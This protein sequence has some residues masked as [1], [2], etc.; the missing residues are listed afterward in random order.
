MTPEGRLLKK[1][2]A[3]ARSQGGHVV[4]LT[5]ARGV[6]AGWPDVLLLFPRGQSLFVELKAPGQRPTPLQEHRIAVLY[7]LGFK[8][9]WADSF[10]KARSAILEALDSAAVHGAGGAA[11]YGDARRG[12]ASPPRRP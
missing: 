6:S 8:A 4:R 12:P 7:E 2:I 10:D 1:V 9:T 3:F 5:F 11:P